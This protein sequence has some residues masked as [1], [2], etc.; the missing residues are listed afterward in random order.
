MATK[1]RKSPKSRRRS[2]HEHD[3]APKPVSYADLARMKG[4]ARS[5]VTR[6]ARPGGALH[7]AV[8]GHN[9]IDLAH[10]ATQLWLGGE[11]FVTLERFAEMKGVSV[12]E[13][14]MDRL[15]P[16][17]EQPIDIDHPAAQE[18]LRDSDI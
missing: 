14:D 11:R 10:P 18:F 2:D 8:L 15:A 13:L 4:C 9:R 17:I 1:P 6:A 3:F 12:A 7:A 5:T 16:A